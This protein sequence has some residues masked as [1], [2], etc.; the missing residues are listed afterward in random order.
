MIRFTLL[1]LLTLAYV[2]FVLL[3]GLFLANFQINVNLDLH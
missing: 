3:I 1:S 2:E